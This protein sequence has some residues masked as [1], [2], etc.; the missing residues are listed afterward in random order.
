M[1][2]PTIVRQTK[3]YL[4]VKIPLPKD[5]NLA[6][7]ANKATNGK[8]AVAERKL[9]KIIK[10]AEEDIRRGRVIT[11]PSIDEALKRYAKQQWD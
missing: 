3:D 2:A 6:F 7:P 4:L 11:A 1:D 5:R 10:E 8:M 9:W